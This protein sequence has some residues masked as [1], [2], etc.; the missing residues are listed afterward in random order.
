MFRKA[1]PA[2]ICLAML[3][4]GCEKKKPEEA[5][6]VRVARGV[7]AVPAG[8]AAVAEGGSVFITKKPLTVGQ[9]LQY[10]EATNQPIPDRWKVFAPDAPELGAPMAG[11][12]RQE[13]AYCATWF[14]K[15]PPT[16]EEWQKA[17]AVVSQRPY[18]WAA[19][20][21]PASPSAEIF[22]V[23]SWAPGSDAEFQARQAKANLA[24]TLMAAHLGEVQRLR[25]EL[26]ALAGGQA[27]G[28][29]TTWA[30]I[31]PTFF[32]LLDQEKKVAELRAARGGRAEVLEILNRLAIAKAKMAAQ[33]A[34]GELSPEAAD[35]AV[36]AY[37]SVLAK[38][39]TEVQGTRDDLQ[40]SVTAAQ[41]EVVALT[42]EVESAGTGGAGAVSEQ[43]QAALAESAGPVQ[44]TEQAV[45]L[46]AKLGAALKSLK[47]AGPALKL[48][49]IEQI[50]ARSAEADQ[51]IKELSAEDP[52]VAQ[53]R[54][55]RQ[56]M[57]QTGRTVEREFLQEKLL[58]QELD[59]LVDLR[60]SK[61]AV[62][63]K[64]KGLIQALGKEAAAKPL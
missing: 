42:K 29:E 12:S 50:K 33:L 10:L 56:K 55:V 31:K 36:A 28:Q 39:R 15:R 24:H 6:P 30:Q 13:T 1:A 47:E 11:L 17:A 58:F 54:D 3:V 49:S 21:T 25:A 35:K 52:A 57:D 7:V 20:G 37:A 5:T 41:D 40:K 59:D 51:Q 61:K 44:S 45:A 9:Y 46:E 4:L 32:S 8:M 27:A 34:A 23:Q 2:V 19:D 48:P 43:A 64:L 62:E 14:L 16:P 53:I 38:T 22:V 26:E 60:A 63:A 18:P